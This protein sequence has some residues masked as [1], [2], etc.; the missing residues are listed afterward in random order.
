[1]Y[2]KGASVSKNLQCGM[3]INMY[4]CSWTFNE[5]EAVCAIIK[6]KKRRFINHHQSYKSTYITSKECRLRGF[7]SRSDILRAVV[8]NPPLSF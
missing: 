6:P 3:L 5:L 7:V 2:R 8:T 4:F 1:M